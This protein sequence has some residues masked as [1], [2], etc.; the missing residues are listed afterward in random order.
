[1]SLLAHYQRLQTVAR[2]DEDRA[3][4]IVR[5]ARPFAAAL[6]PS[7][8]SP[9][10]LHVV[11]RCVAP[12]DAIGGSLIP[13]WPIRH[14][15]GTVTIEHG[16]DW[17]VLLAGWRDAADTSDAVGPSDDSDLDLDA[18][19]ASGDRLWVGIANDVLQK[20]VPDP[21]AGTYSMVRHHAL[22][23]GA[24]TIWL[25][26]ERMRLWQRAHTV[27]ARAFLRGLDGQGSDAASLWAGVEAAEHGLDT[28][29][30][31][32][33]A[34]AEPAEVLRWLDGDRAAA[35]AYRS[36]HGAASLGIAALLATAP[37]TPELTG[38]LRDLV[39]R[40]HSLPEFNRDRVEAFARRV[41]PA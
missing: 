12:S 35:A 31:D 1:M 23:L 13:A 27:A 7:I 5:A 15:D 29:L 3:N 40:E 18:L 37:D 41:G 36:F 33:R 4:E 2:L 21:P 22:M 30:A 16:S 8:P 25:G 19:L 10:D 26:P 17:G 39:Q 9:D 20:L 6:L 28:L 14:D 38:W 32:P 11:A 24:A 34:R